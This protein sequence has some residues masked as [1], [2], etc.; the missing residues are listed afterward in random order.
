MSSAHNL[1][2]FLFT[3]FIVDRLSVRT[4]VH[5]HGTC[6]VTTSRAGDAVYVFGGISDGHVLADVLLLQK[7]RWTLCAHL[8]ASVLGPS[9]VALPASGSRCEV[10]TAAQ[11]ADNASSERTGRKDDDLIMWSWHNL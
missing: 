2:T 7:G 4:R 9:V 10:S 6:V 3:F 5:R 8:Q 11:R 1:I